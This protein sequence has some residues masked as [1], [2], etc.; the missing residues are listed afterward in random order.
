ASSGVAT[1]T[2]LSI[3]KSGSF[4]LSAS[5]GSL[6]GTTSSSFTIVAG[7]SAQV[8]FTVQPSTTTAGVA[9][10]PAVQVSVE[11]KFGNVVTSDTSNVTVSTSTTLNGT[12]TMAASSGVA[13]F[14]N[15]SISKTGSYTLSASDSSLTSAT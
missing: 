3:T 15:L 4:T 7:T 9:I 12:T 6:T 1:F 14:T 8:A 13:T 2:N 5:D 10:S 11:D